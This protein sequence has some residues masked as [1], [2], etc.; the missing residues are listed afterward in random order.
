MN[1][2]AMSVVLV[3]VVVCFMSVV[4]GFF[5]CW[6]RCDI[7]HHAHRRACRKP[8]FFNVHSARGVHASLSSPTGPG[9]RRPGS[10]AA[11]APGR[12][13]RHPVGDDGPAAGSTLHPAMH[14]VGEGWPAGVGLLLP[15]RGGGVPMGGVAGRLTACPRSPARSPALA[16]PSPHVHPPVRRRCDA[17]FMMLPRSEKSAYLKSFLLHLRRLS[18]CNLRIC[19][20]CISK[21]IGTLSAHESTSHP[22][23]KVVVLH[24][25]QH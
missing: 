1:A 15:T 22:F 2:F 9:G 16:R 19:I 11:V 5:G 14:P 4:I 25:L 23:R 6:C 13:R 20:S 17:R 7:H 8:Y 10:R 21:R 18:F 24:G 3:S 12:R